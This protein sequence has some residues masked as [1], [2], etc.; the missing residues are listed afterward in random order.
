MS[1]AEKLNNII[2]ILV[3]IILIF[4]VIFSILLLME[5]LIPFVD[6]IPGIGEGSGV[7]FVLWSL[8][9]FLGLG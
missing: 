8:L 6:Y 7:G 2:R 3:I 9:R 1:L 5:W 4:G